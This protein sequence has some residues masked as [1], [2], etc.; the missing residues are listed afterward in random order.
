MSDEIK[1]IRELNNANFYKMIK[2]IELGLN[3]WWTASAILSIAY[4]SLSEK[5]KEKIR[6]SY[7]ERFGEQF[8][9]INSF[10]ELGRKRNKF[11]AFFLPYENHVRFHKA[12][13]GHYPEPNCIICELE[14]ASGTA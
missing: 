1:K 7:E 2:L 5:Q 10:L 14:S 6:R 3:N 13:T 9:D 11:Q 12:G 8:P 4:D